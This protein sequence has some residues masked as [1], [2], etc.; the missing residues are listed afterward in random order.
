[1]KTNAVLR[2]LCADAD[3]EALQPI[4][5][6]LK[7]KGLRISDAEGSLKTGEI[8]L[9]ALS[10]RF[11]AD[12]EKQKTLLEALSTGSERVF[13][14]NLDG[15]EVPEALSINDEHKADC[16]LNVREA[17]EKGECAE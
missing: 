6:T 8:L 9:A 5:D 1:M 11:Y 12:G 13:P 16:W 10:E 3:K 2:V 4:L 15:S 14:L 7:E 17:T